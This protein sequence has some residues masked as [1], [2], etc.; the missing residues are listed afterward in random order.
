[1][2]ERKTEYLVER[3]KKQDS[4]AFTELMQ[5][6]VKD[7]YKVG[8]AILKNDADV[9]DAMQD[10]I[11]SCWE[12]L[13]SLKQNKYF[14]TW[15]IRILINQCYQLQRKNKIYTGFDESVV[16]GYEDSYNL[17]FKEALDTLE[18]KYRVI[19]IL[20]YV[21]GY[22]IPEISAILKIPKSTVQTRLFRGRKQLAKY[23]DESKK[24]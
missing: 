16:T 7:M 3:A 12:K 4:E 22:R 19:M 13:N 6:Y 23:Y 18:D 1:M 11:L 2:Q 8:I 21:Q 24:R 9:A 5:L 10:T 17:E 15:M 14:K 20:F